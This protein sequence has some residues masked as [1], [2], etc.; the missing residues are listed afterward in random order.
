M[1]RGML[2]GVNLN[3]RREQLMEGTLL[4]KSI[5][6]EVL[7]KFTFKLGLDACYGSFYD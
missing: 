1:K 7:I 4:F 3:F 6:L 2:I 5:N